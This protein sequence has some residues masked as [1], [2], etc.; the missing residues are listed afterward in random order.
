MKEII[1][2]DA[3]SEADEVLFWESVRSGPKCWEWQGTKTHK[4]GRFYI[5]RRMFRAHRVSWVIHYGPI[6]RGL[7]VCHSCD[8]RPCVRPDH[9]FIGTAQDNTDDCVQKGRFY[10][11]RIKDYAHADRHG[12]AKL[13][14]ETAVAAFNEVALGASLVDTARKYGVTKNVIESLVR[15]L[16]WRSVTDVPGVV[17]YSGKKNRCNPIVLE[18]RT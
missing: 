16:T 14:S 1:P 2:L 5:G 8:N 13:T 15:G 6:P 7:L 9:L 17:Y 18:E 4:Y 3:V 12:Q 11:P 10:S